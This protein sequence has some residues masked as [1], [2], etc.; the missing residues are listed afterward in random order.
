MSGDDDTEDEETERE[1]RLQKAAQRRDLD[2][3]A[4]ERV[5]EDAQFT[6]EQTL[7]LFS[8]L[9]G[10]AF[11][12][13]RL[14]AVVLTI[15][16][17]IASQITVRRFVNVPSVASLL[18][19]IGS[20]AF[21]LF[22]YLTTTYNRGFDATAFERSV[23]YRLRQTE[24]LKWVLMKGYPEWIAEGAEKVNRKEL[25]IRRSLVACIAGIATLLVGILFT[26][27]R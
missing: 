6:M 17:A 12:L 18:L 23:E 4:L 8:D 14:N 19:F 3:D 10:K 13:I 21:A 15:L 26:I 22:G 7:Q 5:H 1:R 9:S 25:W 27:Y 2:P 20:A 11:R 24:Y 16:V